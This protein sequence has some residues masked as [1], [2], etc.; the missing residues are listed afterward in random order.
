MSLALLA[1]VTWLVMIVFANIPKRFTLT[2]IIFLYFVSSI[3]TVTV[4]TLFD[5]NFQWVTATRNV[6]KS[7]ALDICRFVEIPLLLIMSSEVLINSS[8]RVGWRWTIAA[9]ICLF[10]TVNDWILVQFGILEYRQWNYVFAFLDYGMFIVLMAWTARWF[11][12]L[13]KGGS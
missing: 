8:L 3:M 1:M 4:F 7:L 12:R 6:E 9:T 13:D 5:E 2:E 10:L 11:V